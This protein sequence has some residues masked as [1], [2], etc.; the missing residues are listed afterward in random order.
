[1]TR[2]DD[3]HD[4]RCACMTR[5]ADP[6]ECS[7]RDEN[8]YSPRPRPSGR[9]TDRRPDAGCCPPWAKQL[10]DMGILWSTAG[11]TDR[12]HRLALTGVLLEIDPPTSTKRLTVAQA[13]DVLA[14]L[15]ELAAAGRL[16]EWARE[17]LAGRA[18]G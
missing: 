14:Q 7:C 4:L 8:G 10:R 13:D 9:L 11:V 3:P 2:L 6:D 12:A 1:M 18:A 16:G 15:G 5:G 17:A